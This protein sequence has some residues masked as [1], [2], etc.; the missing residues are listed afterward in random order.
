[1][2]AS[3]GNADDI[4]G[5]IDLLEIRDLVD[6]WTTSDDV[7]ASKPE[8]D[9][10]RGRPREGRRRSGGDG[11]RHQLGRRGGAR[12][13]GSRRSR[14]LSGGFP[15]AVLREAGAV[16]DLRRR[17]TSC[18]GSSTTRRY[19][20]SRRQPPVGEDP[21]AGLLL[22]AVTGDPLG[23]VDRGDRLAAARA[24]LALA[25]VHLQRHRHLVG[26]RLADDLL[27]VVDR[28]AEHRRARRAGARPPPASI[29][30]PFLNGERRASQRISSTHERPIPAIERWSRSSGWRWPGLVDDLRELLER[31]R[32]PGLGAERR[33]HLLG[34]DVVGVE[35]LAP[36]S[37]LGPELAQPQLATVREP[38]QD[39]R[40]TVPSEARSSK[41]WSLPAD[42]MW[43][44]SASRSPSAPASTTG[45]LPTRRT[46]VTSSPTS[47]SSGGLTLFSATMPGA[48]ADSTV[49]PASAVLEPARGDLD[50]GQLGHGRAA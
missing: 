41:S 8:P 13:P 12:G 5:F 14:V 21:A 4:E 36:G 33:D 7:D 26:D 45:I 34:G 37:L 43:T 50:L 22:R 38:D 17:S 18:A 31:G 15:E 40:T 11:R 20:S 44:S 49:A 27:V 30:E 28:A 19:F 9:L 35:E 48:S 6:D 2:L 1:M 39:S 46:P 23:V 32:R 16:G 47:A 3:S 10:D 29:S 25:P 42:I 24:R